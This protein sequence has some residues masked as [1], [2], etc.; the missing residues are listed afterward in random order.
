MDRAPLPEKSSS[1]D[2]NLNKGWSVTLLTPMGDIAPKGLV[3]VVGRLGK[4]A[5][6]IFLTTAEIQKIEAEAVIRAD[7]IRSKLVEQATSDTMRKAAEKAEIGIVQTVTK[8]G[9][10]YGTVTKVS[11]QDLSTE[12][13]KPRKRASVRR[14]VY[15]L[16]LFEART[17]AAESLE[18]AR[19]EYEA[20][21]R[22]ISI[23]DSESDAQLFY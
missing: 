13:P 8:D 17:A 22:L 15:E 10:S 12:T 19:K 7:E 2:P 9:K 6:G 1:F 20:K 21:G 23:V 4:V 16:D 5:D 11:P 18:V 3:Q 14:E